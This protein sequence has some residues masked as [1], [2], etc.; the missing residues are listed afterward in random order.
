[1]PLIPTFTVSGY[2]GIWGESLNEDIAKAYTAA[3]AK[4]LKED[5]K[6][7]KPVLLIGRDGRESGPTIKGAVISELKKYGISF[8]DGD[9]LPTPTVLFSVKKHQYDGAIIITA[10]HNPIEYNGLKFV[11]DKGLFLGEED[12][13]KI[14]KYAKSHTPDNTKVEQEGLE[15]K[16]VP[17]FP[18]EHVDEILKHVDVEKIR[19]KNFKVAVDMINASAC[20]IDPYLFGELNV[21]LT[22][23]N[24]IPNGKFA[25][26][27]EPNETNLKEVSD[28]MQG[29]D[30][31]I[32]FAHDPDADR[33]VV[34]NESGKVVFEEYTIALCVKNVLS[35]NKGQPIVINLSTS[36]MSKDIADSYG[37]PCSMTKVGEPNVVEEIIKTNAIIGGEGNGGV[38]YPKVNLVRDSFVGIALILDLLAKEEKPISE[39]VSEIPKYAMKKEKWPIKTGLEEI[40]KKLQEKFPEAKTIHIDGIRLDFP[41]GSWLHLHPSNTEPI[42]RLFGEAKTE[43]KIEALFKEAELTFGDN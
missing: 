19:S 35:E 1:M 33:L 23:F 5:L 43:E 2:R 7:E 41:D 31:D 25:H 8:V 17:D 29:K 24:N 26:K 34:I 40:Y 14:D 15:I 27:P 4:L 37:S 18:K 20:V 16:E 22:P 32:G 38:I 21:E 13:S 28:F 42:F 12:S 11:N 30:I 3:F 36:R 9:V 10:S 6:K 39:I